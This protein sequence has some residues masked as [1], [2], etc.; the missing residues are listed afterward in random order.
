MLQ[1]TYRNKLRTLAELQ[2]ATFPSDKRIVL[3]HGVF[4]LVHPGHIRHLTYAKEKADILV[5]SVTADAH[6]TKG[7]YRP[8]VPE[9]LRALNLAVLEFVDYVLIDRNPTPIE[10]I[11]TLQPDLLAKG[12]EYQSGNYIATAAE[13]EA[14]RAHGGDMLFT[15]GDVVYSS[16]H[17][18]ETSPPSLAL[19]KLIM[20]MRAEAIFG[21]DRLKHALQGFRGK[22]VHVVGD[23]IVDSLSYCTLIG[24]YGKTPTP[25]VSIDHRHDFVGGAAIVAQHLRA[26]G[27]TVS[28]S[29]VLGDDKLGVLV[30]D[31][32]EAA[33]VRVNPIIDRT[34][35]TTHKNAF[36]ADGYR[37][38]KVDTLDNRP[39]SD[40][41][42]Q[43]LASDLSATEADAVVYADFRH[44]IFNHNSIP[45]LVAAIPPARFK[46]AD[47]QVASR[48][49]NI[50]DFRGF[51]LITPNEKEARFALGDQD[52]GVRT[53]A[54]NL[55]EQAH[56]KYVMLKLG[57]KGVMVC[58]GDTHDDPRTYFAV[59]SFSRRCVDPVG[60]GDA[61]LAYATLALLV[62][63]SPVVAAI[64]GSLAAAIEC[65][66]DGNI[67]VSCEDVGTRLQEVQKL[68]G[69]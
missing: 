41:Q 4:D 3:A 34:R 25:S 19:E 43:T 52:A 64:L 5:V 18:V 46:V 12:F 8:F 6:I 40:A 7:K 29:T 45:T 39:I 65:E 36:V 27:A 63:D 67:P 14:V 11:R 24:G 57:D 17:I 68:C 44:G 21:F 53:L 1:P 22:H 60:A 38:L 13:A 54:A 10:T 16:S 31:E 55:R 49:G 28:F 50:L 51:D 20:L 69:S 23:T 32:L 26:A 35:P 56:A 42:L 30:L 61:L 47:S 62:D 58:R 59:D 2:R 33:S 48:W 66:A 9:E 15:P 37:M